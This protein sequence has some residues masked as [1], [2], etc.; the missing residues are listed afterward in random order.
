MLVYDW[1]N[2]EGDT[3]NALA[4]LLQDDKRLSWKEADAKSSAG[5]DWTITATRAVRPNTYEMPRRVEGVGY[6]FDRGLATV[7]ILDTP[8]TVVDAVAHKDGSVSM[9]CADWDAI[10]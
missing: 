10:A 5:W 8:I 4:H 6:V 9:S 3:V 7:E 1:E 2:D